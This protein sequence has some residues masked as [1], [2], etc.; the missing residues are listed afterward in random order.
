MRE[1]MQLMLTC[2]GMASS[3]RTWTSSIFSP[4]ALPFWQPCR[5]RTLSTWMP[6]T[7]ET[8]AS[9]SRSLDAVPKPQFWRIEDYAYWGD[10]GSTE[11]CGDPCGMPPRDVRD[12]ATCG[13]SVIVRFRQ[14]HSCQAW[15]LPMPREW[16]CTSCMVAL[17]SRLWL[18]SDLQTFWHTLDTGQVHTLTF[19]I[20]CGPA[21]VHCSSARPKDASVGLWTIWFSAWTAIQRDCDRSRFRSAAVSLHSLSGSLFVSTVAA[22]RFGTIPNQFR[23]STATDWAYWCLGSS[24]N[25]RITLFST[26]GSWI[27]MATIENH[28]HH[29]TAVH[30]TAAKAEARQPG[31]W[32]S[33]VRTSIAPRRRQWGS[34]TMERGAMEMAGYWLCASE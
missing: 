34:G 32:R 3:Q 6:R 7:R 25:G 33:D 4:P 23:G 30:C 17:K 24:L 1:H 8:R 27:E 15:K 31:G 14:T 18:D 21:Q 28:W 13:A 5:S 12:V 2:G 9:K 22:F 16:L 29:G 19:E 26:F 11:P 20:C 10:G